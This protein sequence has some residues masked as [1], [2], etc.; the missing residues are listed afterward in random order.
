MPQRRLCI[1]D[2]ETGK[3]TPTGNINTI[4]ITLTDKIERKTLKQCEPVPTYYQ[5]KFA[6]FFSFQK[7]NNN[8]LKQFVHSLS[9]TLKKN[10]T[11][12]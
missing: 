6:I 11:H 9:F 5:F 7:Y 8:I 3:L 10:H 12:I 1:E 2:Y 4:Q